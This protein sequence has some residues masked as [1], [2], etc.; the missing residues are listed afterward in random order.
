[1]Q[2]TLKISKLLLTT[3]V[4]VLVSGG[5]TL[6]PAAAA[7]PTISLWLGAGAFTAISSQCAPSWTLPQRL[8]GVVYRPDL[9][10]NG[11]ETGLSLST[12]EYNHY[13][14]TLASGTLFGTTFKTVTA[15][16][17]GGLA[18]VIHPNC[19]FERRM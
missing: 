15:T 3:A 4:A 9:P 11:P 7:A 2:H 14:I 8:V 18:L 12:G 5:A 19:D 17:M 13:N 6:S 1:M 10:N 16:H